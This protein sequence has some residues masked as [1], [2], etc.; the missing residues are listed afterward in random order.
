MTVLQASAL[1][2]VAIAGTAVV[3]SP[4]PLRQVVVLGVYGLSLTTLFFVFEAP[5]VALSEIVVSTLGLPAMVLLT[6]RKI[7]QHEREQED[8]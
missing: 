8:E 4:E 5:D 3:F 7:R 1:I 2:V 6:L